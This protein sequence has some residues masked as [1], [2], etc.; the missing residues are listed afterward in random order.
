MHCIQHKT[1][2]IH[3]EQGLRRRCSGECSPLWKLKS[4]KFPM[5]KDF[6][7]NFPTFVPFKLWMPLN[8]GMHIFHAWKVVQPKFWDH[9]ISDTIFLFLSSM[10]V[11][12][13]A[14]VCEWVWKKSIKA[15][16][17][18]KRNNRLKINSESHTQQSCI[19]FISIYSG[20]ISRGSFFP[21]Q[22]KRRERASL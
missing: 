3:F 18:T 11:Y 19:S 9:L 2:T 4:F 17:T 20:R 22:P 16:R 6:R 13:Y 5:K 1:A 15:S 12:A 14:Y 21:F 7:I 8:F 10:H